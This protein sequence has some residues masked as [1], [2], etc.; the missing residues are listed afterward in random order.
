MQLR[1]EKRG[2]T[3]RREYRGSSA[4]TTTGQEPEKSNEK[5]NGMMG[6]RSGDPGRY[7]YFRWN[8][9]F[10]T[11]RDMEYTNWIPREK[12]TMI[13]MGRDN[14]M[15]FLSLSL[16]VCLGY[17]W[18]QLLNTGW[19]LLLIAASSFLVPVAPGPST[20]YYRRML[21]W[22]DSELRIQYTCTVFY[23]PSTLY[24]GVEISGNSILLHPSVLWCQAAGDLDLYSVLIMIPYGHRMRHGHDIQLGFYGE[25]PTAP[26]YSDY[27]L[28]RSMLCHK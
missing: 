10:G 24:S 4:P 21:S 9:Y 19:E 7:E 28:G 2:K 3:R 1:G 26:F 23:L 5:G 15:R 6:S 13:W 11:G 25:L 22:Y 27:L 16:S 14:D 17:E 20:G 8:E 18:Q 12:G